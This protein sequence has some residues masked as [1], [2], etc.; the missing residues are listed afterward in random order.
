MGANYAPLNTKELEEELHYSEDPSVGKAL[1][2]L[3][4][5]YAGYRYAK[6]ARLEQAYQNYR[7]SQRANR[8]AQQQQLT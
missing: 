2:Y 1:K 4:P 7:D 8:A 5:G 6:D 3:I